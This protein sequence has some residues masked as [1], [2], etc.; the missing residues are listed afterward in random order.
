MTYL[1]DTNVVSEWV[2][3]RPDPGVVSW[4]AEAQEDQVFVSV[5]TLAELRFGA[6]RMPAGRRR[7]QLDSWL[8]HDVPLR[9][10][11]RII[12][13]DTAIADAWGWINARGKSTGQSIDVMDGLIAATAE[14][15]RLTVVTRDESVFQGIGAPV[16]N[17]W[18][19][20]R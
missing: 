15:F 13:V 5:C 16:L 12:P 8:S 1:L 10:E 7:D 20:G 6:A 3:P 9:F 18:T 4:L 19:K 2:K 17:P 11:G 14:T